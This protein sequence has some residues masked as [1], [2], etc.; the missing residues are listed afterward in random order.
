LPT[1]EEYWR[2][3]MATSA[4]KVTTAALLLVYNRGFTIVK[5][6]IANSWQL[7]VQSTVACRCAGFQATG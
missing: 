1:L 5:A 7:C 4:V 3:R 6:P 2:L